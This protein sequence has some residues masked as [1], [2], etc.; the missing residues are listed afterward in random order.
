MHQERVLLHAPHFAG[1]LSVTLRF[2]Q[3]QILVRP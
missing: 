2:F 1:R 3:P